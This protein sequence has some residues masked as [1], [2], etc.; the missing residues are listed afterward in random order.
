MSFTIVISPDELGDLLFLKDTVD[1]N[2]LTSCD[3]PNSF[4]R[5]AQRPVQETNNINMWFRSCNA[6]NI[7]NRKP[8][9]P[10][11]LDFFWSNQIFEVSLILCCKQSQFLFYV[12]LCWPNSECVPFLPPIPN[13]SPCNWK[14]VDQIS[15]KNRNTT[16]THSN[17][18]EG[19]VCFTKR[20][21]SMHNLPITKFHFDCGCVGR[22]KQKEV[23][24]C[25]R[26]IC[27]C[28]YRWTQVETSCW[29]M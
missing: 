29:Y 25:H 26:R 22:E 14:N 13:T 1:V 7:G 27:A 23:E 17:G 28:G 8:H 16:P 19:S 12:K 3:S 18:A 5:V 9:S 24:N 20:R 4:F 15:R 2:N 21:K 10:S 11:T 6:R